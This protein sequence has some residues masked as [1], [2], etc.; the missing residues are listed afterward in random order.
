MLLHD[1]TRHG[2]GRGKAAENVALLELA[3]YLFGPIYLGLLAAVMAAQ[4]GWQGYRMVTAMPTLLRF[5]A[6][7]LLAITALS[8]LP[9]P[10]Y[11][12][13]NR[14]FICAIA[15]L[16]FAV[17]AIFTEQRWFK[18]LATGHVIFACT[19]FY[20]MVQAAR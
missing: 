11:Q 8:L 10:D 16:P 9:Y 1:Q 3:Q 2:R 6:F 17:I 18:L 14:G 7:A 20:V 13:L 4:L 15:L 5:N 12:S 19:L